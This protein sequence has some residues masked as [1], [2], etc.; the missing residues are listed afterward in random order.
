[1]NNMKTLPILN[2]IHIEK[3]AR[4]LNIDKYIVAFDNQLPEQKRFSFD[5]EELRS[6]ISNILFGDRYI[7][8]MPDNY[9]EWINL[10]IVFFTGIGRSSLVFNECGFEEYLMQSTT[11]KDVNKLD[12]TYQEKAMAENTPVCEPS[13]YSFFNCD[14]WIRY[15]DENRSL[16]YATIR[17]LNIQLYWQ[18]ENAATNFIYKQMPEEI[19][20][21]TFGGSSDIKTRNQ[22]LFTE[23]KKIH[24][25]LNDH[26]C[27]I[28]NQIY[29]Q[30]LTLFE[31]S[32]PKAFYFRQKDQGNSPYLVVVV[33]DNAGEMI[34][35]RTFNESFEMTQDSRIN[36][37]INREYIDSA[38][39]SDYELLDQYFTQQES[40]LLCDLAHLYFNLTGK[41]AI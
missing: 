3:I 25:A 35:L 2:N 34:N 31:N 15:I 40:K 4:A 13:V 33:P 37:D 39:H 5:H 8:D 32:P 30:P 29:I 38:T 26:A 23:W 41:K 6:V 21:V 10:Y 19:A 16:K 11:L 17:T 12:F 14:Y 1:M 22:K 20:E 28:I 24:S 18:L 7:Q 9:N 27:S 36:A